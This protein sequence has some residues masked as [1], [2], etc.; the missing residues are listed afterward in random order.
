MNSIPEEVPHTSAS[1]AFLDSLIVIDTETGGTDPYEHS[2]LTIAMLSG[3][4]RWRLNATI[5]EDDIIVT[6][7]AMEINRLDLDVVRATGSAPHEAIK[8]IEAFIGTEKRKLCGW[9]VAFDQGFLQ[10]LYRLAGQPYPRNLGHRTVDL[11]A[12]CAYLYGVGKLPLL[13]SSDDAFKHFGVEPPEELRHT[14]M[15]DAIATHELLLRL[16]QVA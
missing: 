10:R 7:R 15:G 4:G 12:I 1:K 9:N 13:A 2:L 8:G 16:L 11:H 3:N 5:V 14:A 6:P